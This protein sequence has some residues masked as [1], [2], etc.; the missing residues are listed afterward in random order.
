MDNK[1]VQFDYRVKAILGEN[2]ISKITA[3]GVNAVIECA[4][5]PEFPKGIA[6]VWS[7]ETFFLAAIAGCYVNTFQSFCDKFKLQPVS[8]ECEA[9]GTIALVEGKY[10]FTG[11]MLNPIVT[12]ANYEDEATAYK[13]L[14]K[15]HRYCLISNS[16]K[17][18]VSVSENVLV[19]IP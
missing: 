19:L 7:P 3:V 17:C 16:I 14:E 2:R 9:S 4:T 15:A 6:G 5:P 11:V 10:A 8:L 18:P 12:L 13:I 1:E